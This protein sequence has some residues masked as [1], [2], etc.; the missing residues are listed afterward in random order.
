MINPDVPEDRQD[1]RPRDEDQSSSHADG[2]VPKGM[3]EEAWRN[4]DS[5][6]V[7]TGFVLSVFMLVLCV[8]D[9][10]MALYFMVWLLSPG[11]K[12]GTAGFALVYAP[13][14]WTFVLVPLCVVALITVNF[15]GFSTGSRE[16][17]KHGTLFLLFGLLG[18]MII[19]FAATV[20]TFMM[21]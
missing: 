14:I 18:S 1:A 3:F 8:L 4:C 12:G 2:T 15:G 9:A 6:M 10:G 16:L 17:K 20:I 5:V 7:K 13:L 21:A 11:F 19:V